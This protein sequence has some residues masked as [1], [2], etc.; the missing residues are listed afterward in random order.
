MSR[1]GLGRIGHATWLRLR[2]RLWL[3]LWALW[4]LRLLWR[5]RWR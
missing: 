5:G 4:V 1:H 2:L 3:R